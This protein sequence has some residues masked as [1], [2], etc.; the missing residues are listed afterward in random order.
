MNYLAS[1]VEAIRLNTLC[2]FLLASCVWFAVNFFFRS[3]KGGLLAVARGATAAAIATAFYCAGLLFMMPSAS[4]LDSF[5]QPTEVADVQDP[6]KLLKI[7]QAQHTALCQSIII[8][9]RTANALFLASLCAGFHGL[10][11][12]ARMR[13]AQKEQDYLS[14]H[15]GAVPDAEGEKE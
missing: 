12:L 3:L 10:G 15:Q 6:K 5:D 4:M 7:I 8:Q 9:D 2:L 13:S 14:R 1:A 11:F